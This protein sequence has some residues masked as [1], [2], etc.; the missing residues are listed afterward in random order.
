MLGVDFR[1]QCHKINKPFLLKFLVLY[2]EDVGCVQS[3]DGP[4]Q[5]TSQKMPNKL[6]IYD[7]IFTKHA[8]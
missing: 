7:Q 2:R 1:S 3:D 8:Q 5:K 6:E 4:P